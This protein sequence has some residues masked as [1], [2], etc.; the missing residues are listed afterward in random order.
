MG[1]EM[2]GSIFGKIVQLLKALVHQPQRSS[3]ENNYN[4]DVDKEF[5]QR[6]ILKTVTCHK[7]SVLEDLGL[8]LR[9]VGI[10]KAGGFPFDAILFPKMVFSPNFLTLICIGLV[11]H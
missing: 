11:V 7:K 2:E 4:S 6:G 5:V 3:H 10:A 1:T 9:F 8:A